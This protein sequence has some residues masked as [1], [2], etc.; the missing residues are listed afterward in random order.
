MANRFPAGFAES[1]K[2]ISLP[3]RHRPTKEKGNNYRLAANG[4]ARAC[5]VR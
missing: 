3:K 2:K 5:F 4:L 1:S